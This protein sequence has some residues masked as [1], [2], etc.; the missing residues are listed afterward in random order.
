MCGTYQTEDARD[1][2]F[3]LVKELVQPL[4]RL[5]RSHGANRGQAMA[6]IL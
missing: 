6:R 1:D 5:V 4:I 3:L 2:A